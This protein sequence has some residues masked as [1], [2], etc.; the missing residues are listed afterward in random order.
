[1]FKDP[2]HTSSTSTREPKRYD[3]HL[4]EAL[5]LKTV[6]V[7]DDLPQRIADICDE[8]LTESKQELLQF[9]FKDL[10]PHRQE[11]EKPVINEESVHQRYA[12]IGKH[13]LEI[14][15]ALAFKT[16]NGQSV[17]EFD[18]IA[19]TYQKDAR[20]DGFLK[21]GTGIDKTVL[22]KE[23]RQDIALIEKHDLHHPLIWEF[24][25]LSAGSLE[26]MESIPRLEGAFDWIDCEG[27]AIHGISCHSQDHSTNGVEAIT[28]RPTGPDAQCT[29]ENLINRSP[30][31]DLK[32]I[33]LVR[34]K[35]NKRIK[36][37]HILQQVGF[38]LSSLLSA[39]V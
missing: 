38:S 13:C 14:A 39:S 22:S 25:S 37:V 6:S 11:D 15:S 34:L 5:R 17:F 8:Y 36:S 26:V 3:M 21:I 29:A 24:K 7:I 4:D 16:G 9:N 33:S 2:G 31:N 10:P 27:M 1:M 28:G 32:P 35:A 18:L 19:S 12:S 20:A 23:D 30:K